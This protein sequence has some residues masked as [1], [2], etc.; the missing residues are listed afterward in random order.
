[1]LSSSRMTNKQTFNTTIITDIYDRYSTNWVYSETLDVET[2]YGE[3]Y[4]VGFAVGG[5]HIMI[6]AP[7]ALD[8]S[9]VSGKVFDYLKSRNTYSWTINHEEIEKPDVSKIKK[10]F[11]Y[12]RK[13]G[14]LVKYLDVVDVA[15]GKV[16]GPAAEELRYNTFYDPAV[17]SLGS[18]TVNVDVDAPWNKEQVGRLWWDLRTA[19]FLNGYD[20]DVVYRTSVWNTLA[21]GAS[22]DI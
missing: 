18:S 3:G 9:I 7:Y 8:Q 14:E 22:V 5:E 12:N 4:G 16:P 2:S 19:K 13:S 6:G 17:Y 20:S 15:Q 1:M 21:T 10:A 11:L